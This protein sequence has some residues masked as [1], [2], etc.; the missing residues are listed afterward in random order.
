MRTIGKGTSITVST[1]SV[2]SLLCLQHASAQPTFQDYVQYATGGTNCTGISLADFDQDGDADVFASHR[3]TNNVIVMLNDG[4]GVFQPGPQCGVGLMPRYVRAGDLN[5]DGRPDFATPD[6]NGSTIS[7]GLQDGSGQLLLHQQMD[8]YRPAI[9]ELADL[10]LDGDLDV[11]VPH[12][13]EAAVQP[14]VA[15]SLV[16]TLIN[17]GTG[18]FSAGTSVSIGVQPRGMEIDDFN[19]DGFPDVIVCNLQSDDVTLLLN[20]GDGGFRDAV[21]IAAPDSP[22]EICT[23]DWNRDGEVDYAVVSK[24]LNQIHFMVNNG[25]EE[26]TELIWHETSNLPHSCTAAD[27]DG[28]G[29]ADVVASHVGSAQILIYE[30]IGSTLAA[31]FEVYSPSGGAEVLAGSLDDND[32]AD[33]VTG[34]TN[35]AT[36]SVHLNED[37]G[38]D[39]GISCRGDID[40]NNLVDVLDLLLVISEWGACFGDLD[41]LRSDV[42]TDGQVDVLDVLQIIAK[43]GA[44][45]V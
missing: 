4:D 37:T 29:D 2:L 9:L 18:Q 36:I 34:N 7:I 45:D 44:C 41:C 39:A 32:S 6:Y 42:N 8:L 14:S 22:R 20:D 15:P 5:G 19:R 30:N 11:V 40:R 31:P 1:A 43:W 21:T 12:W 38:G 13:D 28:D 24:S 10:D 17:D 26:F 27:L 35:N 33:I 25:E 3:N 16:A 23:G